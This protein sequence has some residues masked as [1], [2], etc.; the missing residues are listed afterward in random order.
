MPVNRN[1]LIRYKTIDLCLQNKYRRWTLDDLITACSEAL[2]EY[3]GVDKGISRRTIQLDIQLMRSDK[4]GYNAPIVVTE[5]KYYAYED[6]D[7]SIINI[8]ISESDLNKLMETVDFLKQFKG[9]SHFKELDTMVQ[10][11]EDHV[12]AKK[13][14]RKPVIDFEKNENLKGLEF[15]EMLYQAIIRKNIIELTYQSFNARQA[16]TFLFHPYLLKEFRN[17]WFLIGAKNNVHPIL[18]LAIDRIQD[19][20][21]TDKIFL[22]EKEFDAEAYFK[23]VIGVTVNHP[24]PPEKIVLFVNRKH[25]PYVLTK[26]L[27]H[28]QKLIEKDEFGI[29]ISLEVQHNFELEKEILGLGD[30]VVVISPDRLKANVIA[31]L[32]NA[33]DQYNTIFSSKDMT[34]LKRRYFQKGFCTI[35]QLYTRK[36]INQL[37]L[38]LSKG[39]QEGYENGEATVINF[40]SDQNSRAILL[41]STTEQFFAQITDNTKACTIKYYQGIPESFFEFAQLDRP[42]KLLVIILLAESKSSSFSIQV[43]PGS[44]NKLLDNEKV[45]WIIENSIPVDCPIR[46]G[47]AIVCHPVLLKRFSPTLKNEKVHFVMMEFTS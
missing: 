28:S 7:Y 31:R 17:R 37:E 33:V 13:I 47:G 30:G 26:P 4:L 1:A 16:S 42:N 32:N 44:Q 25:A 39:D 8:P 43:L 27:H 22:Q 40:D 14:N 21:C 23:N 34:S 3:E 29:T 36:S 35:N 10:K 20:K 11:L 24:M 2:Y 19:V 15:L 12:Y 9:F 41:N 45:G 38:A 46:I 6:P 5:K 18:N